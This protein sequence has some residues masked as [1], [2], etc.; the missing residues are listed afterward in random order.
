M[1]RNHKNNSKNTFCNKMRANPVETAQFIPSERKTTAI[2]WPL[3]FDADLRSF[4]MHWPHDPVPGTRPDRHSLELWISPKSPIE[5]IED[6]RL[7][8]HLHDHIHGAHSSQSGSMP[9]KTRTV[10]PM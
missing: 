4:Q 9:S 8:I 2:L 5:R 6:D 3:V 1:S 7:P 10:Y